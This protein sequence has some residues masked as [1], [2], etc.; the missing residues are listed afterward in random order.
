MVGPGSRNAV[1]EFRPILVYIE[2]G[3]ARLQGL[4]AALCIL[5]GSR[6][7]GLSQITREQQSAQLHQRLWQELPR[8]DS[9]WLTSHRKA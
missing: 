4:D 3:A 7:F 9:Y 2:D 8:P 1:L 6:P 5:D